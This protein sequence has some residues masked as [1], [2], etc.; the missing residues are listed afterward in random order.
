M[1]RSAQEERV[2]RLAR[3]HGLELKKAGLGEPR[4]WDYGRYRL[5]DASRN[6]LVF[7]DEHG[8]SLD[9]LE[10]YLTQG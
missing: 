7:P 4:A 5:E 3:R 9:D 2:R 8:T 6:T 1:P 10:R